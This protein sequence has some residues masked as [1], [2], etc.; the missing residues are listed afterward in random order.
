MSESNAPPIGAIAW[1]DL[2]VDDA[3][4]IRDFYEEVAG[5]Q[6][7][8]VDMGGYKDF[9]MMAS[10]QAIAGICH[11]R[12]ANADLPSQW[13]IYIIVDHLDERIERCRRL[14]GGVLV[15]PKQMGAHGRYGIIR[16]PAGAVCALFEPA[17]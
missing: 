17:C 8:P 4:S 9:N 2:T 13:M 3:E 7:S 12:G 10:D 16:D 1:T 14:G 6:P 15:E 5:W 11:R